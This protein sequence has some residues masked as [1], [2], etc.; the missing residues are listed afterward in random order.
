MSDLSPLL[1][2]TN[3]ELERLLLLSADDDEPDAT[4]L[5]RV[6]AVLGVGAMAVGLSNAGSVVAEQA[7]LG[8][9]AAAKPLTLVSLAKLL[10]VGATAGVLTSGTAYV[11]FRPAHSQAPTPTVSALPVATTASPRHAAA[12]EVADPTPTPEEPAP[13]TTAVIPPP[14]PAAEPVE[15]DEMEPPAV[16]EPRA[17][18]LGST[19]SFD[20]PVEATTSAAEARAASTLSEEVRALDTVRKELAIGRARSAL[21]D[22]DA[23]RARFPN[24]AL[25]TE[26]TVLRVE[27]LLGA[28]ER[29]SA[30]REAARL[31]Q[32]APNSRHAERV[33]ELLKR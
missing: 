30:E 16:A 2:D 24:G 9:A 15:P 13:A 31:I 21:A 26:A 27:A 11:A 8:G 19:A 1:S 22:L 6:A 23:Y 7:A 28:G 5:P 14:P 29:A 4:A 33:R 10:A 3:D 18:A 12:Q 32:A 25:T 20:A 17:A